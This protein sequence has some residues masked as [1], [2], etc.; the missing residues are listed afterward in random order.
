MKHED[1]PHPGTDPALQP[2]RTSLSIERATVEH[3]RINRPVGGPLPIRLEGAVVVV[4]L[5]EECEGGR[6]ILR[7]EIRVRRERVD[8][9]D[10][11]AR[12]G[13]ADPSGN[14]GAA[15]T[16]AADRRLHDARLTGRPRA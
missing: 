15:P 5:V 10:D 6:W 1:S 2:R 14:D 4:P 8:L 13:L 12:A 7:E 9:H 11:G 3:R 16:G